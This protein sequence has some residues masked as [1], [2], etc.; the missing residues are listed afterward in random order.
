MS[1]DACLT[2]LPRGLRALAALLLAGCTML[3]LAAP[4]IYDYKVLEKRPLSRE[5]FVQG[6]EIVDS[7]LYLGTGLYGRSAVQEYEWPALTLR[8]QQSLPSNLF[9]EGISRLGERVYQ[10]TWR[11][12]L[13]LIREAATLEQITTHPIDGEGWGLTNDGEA[14]IYSDGSPTLRFLD[15]DGLAETR[16]LQVTLNGKP[17][18]RLN[19]L[20]WIEGEIWANVWQANQLVRIDPRSG[21][22]R[23]IVDLRGLLDPAERRADTDVLNGIAYDRTARE[24]WVTGKRWPWLY[25]IALRPRGAQP[26]LPLRRPR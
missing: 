24:I 14:L 12:G 18:P 2:R 1:P 7:T 22:V 16:R 10:L 4:A 6:L 21:E 25:R 5:L 17:L 3:S 8:Q 9:G 26:L 23:G 11:A 20:E 19:E 13:L 15:P